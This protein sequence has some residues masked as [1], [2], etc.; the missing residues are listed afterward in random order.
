[1]AGEYDC[2]CGELKEFV[3]DTIYESVFVTAV[4]V[5]TSAAACE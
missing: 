1:V 3:F 5:A 2:F 4:E